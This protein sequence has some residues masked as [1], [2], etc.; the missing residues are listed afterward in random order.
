MIGQCILRA[1]PLG[2]SLGLA[3]C[4]ETDFLIISDSADRQPTQVSLR[5]RR[6]HKVHPVSACLSLC[7]LNLRLLQIPPKCRYRDLDRIAWS[8]SGL[9][10]T[11]SELKLDV[12]AR[13]QRK[14][15]IGKALTT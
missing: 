8:E 2:H 7:N 1:L 11:V 9:A 14:V 5:V 15:V 10:R 13:L 3:N 12:H 4:Q 6:T